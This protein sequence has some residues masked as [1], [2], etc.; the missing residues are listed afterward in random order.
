MRSLIDE[1]VQDI[2]PSFFKAYNIPNDVVEA[3]TNDIETRIYSCVKHW[4][5]FEFR[6]VLLTTGLEEAS[7]Y[8]PKE[9]IEVRCFVVV[10]IRNSLFENLVS[11]RKAAM[12]LGLR[13]STIPETDVK[14]FTQEAI[15][16]FKDATFENL[17]NN[18]IID[19]RRDI[20][21]D[22]KEKYPVA[23]NALSKLGI[24]SNKAQVFP[25]IKHEPFK[26]SELPPIPSML[27]EKVIETEIQSGIDDKLDSILLNVLN[28]ISLELNPL[29]YTDCFKA[30]TRNIDKLLKVIE[31]VLRKDCI[32]MTSNFYISNGYVSKRKDLLRPAHDEADAEKNL[33]QFN[34]LRQTHLKAF[35]AVSNSI[36]S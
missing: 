26:I 7:F 16:H 29:F 10:A 23:W 14:I 15:M 17:F 31:Y 30:L 6:R 32:F 25:S 21:H 20:F 8:E 5:D 19:E 3:V 4:S 12:E 11:N 36:L 2:L 35:K 27:T 33:K 28:S 24:W 34:G 18:L 13:R 1:Y 9:D 22:L